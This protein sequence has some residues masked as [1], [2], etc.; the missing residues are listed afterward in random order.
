MKTRTEWCP[1][2]DFLSVSSYNS[3][4]FTQFSLPMR[5]HDN[6]INIPL[7]PLKIII[8]EKSLSE[9]IFKPTLELK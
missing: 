7:V 8:T 4:H 6:D 5:L 3:L 2:A 9:I 1:T